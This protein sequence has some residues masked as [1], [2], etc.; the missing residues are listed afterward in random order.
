MPQHRVTSERGKVWLVS[1][2]EAALRALP[3]PGEEPRALPG[4]SAGA[5]DDP[6][7]DW[8]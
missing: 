6:F 3:R 5:T 7:D 1:E 2:L 4:S 8:K